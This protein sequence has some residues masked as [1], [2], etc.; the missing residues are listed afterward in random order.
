MFKDRNDQIKAQIEYIIFFYKFVHPTIT[1][2]QIKKL[3]KEYVGS[4]V[5][6]DEKFMKK[7]AEAKEDLEKAELENDSRRR[8]EIYDFLRGIKSTAPVPAPAPTP[9][10]AEDKKE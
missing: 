7:F 10:P 4:F 8:D 1:G 5:K 2:K 9:T 3:R 6:E